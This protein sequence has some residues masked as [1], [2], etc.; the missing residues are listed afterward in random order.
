MNEAKGLKFVS[1][2][3]YIIISIVLIEIGV[4]MYDVLLKD[5]VIK[6]DKKKFDSSVTLILSD[7]V[8]TTTINGEEIVVEI[9]G[10]NYGK[11]SCVSNDENK[12]KCEIKDNK[13]HVIPQKDVGVV[14]I[15][16]IE[17]KE[18]KKVTLQFKIEKKEDN[19]YVASVEQ[20]QKPT[21]STI[22]NYTPV[23]T[24]VINTTLALS[25]YVGVGYVNGNNVIIGITG[26][27]FGQ[28]SCVSSDTQVA[29]CEIS[30]NAVIVSPQSIV[31]TAY[32]T[33][34]ENRLNKTQ[35]FQIN[36]KKEYECTEGS[37][38]EAGSNN[39]ICLVDGELEYEE[40]CNRY[41][42]TQN[43]SNPICVDEDLT[44]VYNNETLVIGC[45][46]EKHTDETYHCNNQHLCIITEIT[47]TCVDYD[48]K[49]TYKC[50]TGFYKYSGNN[51]TLKCYKSATLKK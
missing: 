20:T 51:E 44:G 25:G 28:L 45:T 5:G 42:T 22:V 8:G 32:I 13:L 29:T 37:L 1:M 50:P 9:S 18:N 36:V 24:P 11:L 39:Y 49:A 40:V 43:E 21:P 19:N 30:G 26:T 3:P 14:N 4:V 10:K 2:I 17:D 38:F 6:L 31:G 47:K 48:Y 33:I 15:D 35:V 23:T 7:T 41:Y 16:V 12:A 27:N 46:S 34:K